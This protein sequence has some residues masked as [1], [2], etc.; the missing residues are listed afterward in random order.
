[1]D[2]P[3]ILFWRP[4]HNDG[5]LDNKDIVLLH[6]EVLAIWALEEAELVRAEHS[7]LAKVQKRNHTGD[8]EEPVA[9]TTIKLQYST[10]KMVHSLEWSNIDRLLYF[11]GKIYIP[12][13]L[14]LCR[15]IIALCHNTKITRH[16]SYWKTLELVSHNHWWPQMFQYM[17]QYVS[18]CDLCL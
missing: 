9:K 7:I 1:M 10:S 16:S 5:S 6:S 15:N 11:R 3:D 12:W 4:N 2:K 8:L 13:T 14:D 17:G 18:T